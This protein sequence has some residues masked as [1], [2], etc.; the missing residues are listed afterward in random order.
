MSGYG[1]ATGGDGSVYF[2]TGDGTYNVNTANALEL[3]NSVVR[4]KLVSGKI[5]VLDWYSPQNRDDLKRFDTDLGS[6]GAVPVPNSHLLLAGGKEG[7][8]YLIDRND[9]G[10][11]T[12]PSLHSFQVTNPPLPR[13]DNPSKAG[14]ILYWNI[15]GSPVVWPRQDQMFVYIMGEEDRLKQYK[16]V[17]DAGPAGW[18]FASDTPFKQS[19]EAAAFPNP[20][21]GLFHD[22]SR[23][24]IWMPGGFLT[25][26]ANGSDG[27]SAI[28][29]ATMPFNANANHE[30]VRGVL[31]AF[32][33]LDISK[34]QIWSSEDFGVPA[35]RL[36]W[37]AKFNPPVVA[38]GK[39]YVAAF[40]QER[41]D[42]GVHLKAEGGD[43]PALVIYGLK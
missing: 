5:Q 13:F 42:N 3:G 33:A 6:A 27:A 16:M 28:V 21:N 11:G 31:R 26:S 15:H 32:D 35:D 30:V 17:P 19:K 24:T 40:Q 10:R 20:P 39:V 36:G 2:V 29:W 8:L 22:K 37:F 25:L 14:D 23:N 1:L 41:I 12:K 7:R 18:K 43:Q 4:I 9:M 38:N 34:G